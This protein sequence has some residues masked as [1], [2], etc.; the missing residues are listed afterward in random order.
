MDNGTG[1]PFVLHGGVIVNGSTFAD[2]KPGRL[3]PGFHTFGVD[4][5]PDHITWYVDG[6][7][8]MTTTDPTLIPNTPMY[9]IIDLA[10]SNGKVW[11]LP[12]VPATPFPATVSVDYIHVFQQS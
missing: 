10:V 8:W 1:N 5:E 11:G 6:K 9:P 3:T 2:Q 12:P 7:P 4:W